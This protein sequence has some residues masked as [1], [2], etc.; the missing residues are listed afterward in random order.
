[1]ESFKRLRSLV[2][3]ENFPR[4]FFLTSYKVLL[5]QHY[6]QLDPELMVVS[7]VLLLGVCARIITQCDLYAGIL[8]AKSL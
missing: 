1:M 3:V 2:V 6:H 8:A 4:L 7:D 5:L